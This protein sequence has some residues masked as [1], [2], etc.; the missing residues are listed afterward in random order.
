MA[1]RRRTPRG[2]R[3]RPPSA[4]SPTT[5][6]EVSPP[7][8]A[9]AVVAEFPSLGSGSEP[10]SPA[11]EEDG[12]APQAL[13]WLQRPV[14]WA[15]ACGIVAIG[16]TGLPR[17]LQLPVIALLAF[18]PWLQQSVSWHRRELRRRAHRPRRLVASLVAV[19]LVAAFLMATV[20]VLGRVG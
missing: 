5:V 8:H 7:A 1:R 13:R 10:P 20:S 9:S 2:E 6:D 16:L 17:L 18:V 3:G 19:A 14:V 15:A 4:S 11:A 12:V